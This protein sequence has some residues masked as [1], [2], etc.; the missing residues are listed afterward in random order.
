VEKWRKL[1]PVLIAAGL[2]TPEN[3]RTLTR[4]LELYAQQG[5]DPDTL[6]VPMNFAKGIMTLGPLP[7]GPAPAI[8]QRQ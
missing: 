3:S 5:S 8:F 1:I 6:T 4:A 2:L 7:L